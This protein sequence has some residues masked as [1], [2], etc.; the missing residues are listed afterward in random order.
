MLH[1]IIAECVF[2]TIHTRGLLSQ[3]PRVGSSAPP[4]KAGEPPREP[5]TEHT[6]TRKKETRAPYRAR[7]QA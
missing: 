2:F 7:G 6:Q 4:A 1:Y 3:L 5:K